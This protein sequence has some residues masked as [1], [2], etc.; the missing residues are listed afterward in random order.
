MHES[1]PL[2]RYRGALLAHYLRRLANRISDET[3]VILAERDIGLDS[4]TVSTALMLSVRPGASA[5]DLAG[6]LGLSHQLVSQRVTKLTE[7]G[8]VERVPSP[9]DKRRRQ[10]VLTAAGRREVEKMEPILADSQRVFEELFREIDVDLGA[11]V[12]SAGEA[13]EESS[14]LHRFR[15]LRRVRQ[16]VGSR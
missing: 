16:E 12:R 11:A 1:N 15:A 9:A 13:L 6:W 2:D 4:R 5:A 14:M 3:A 7:G 10:L 8:F